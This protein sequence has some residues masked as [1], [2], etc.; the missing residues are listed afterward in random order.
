[1]AAYKYVLAKAEPHKI[2]FV[3]DSA[4]GGLLLATMLAARVENL[5]LPEAAVCYSPLADLAASGAS[6]DKNNRRCAMFYGNSIRRVAPVYL[7]EA[8][9]RNPLA[10]PIYADFRGFP[11]LQIFVSTTE[12]LLDDSIRLAEK[13]RISGVTVDLQVWRNLP[14]VWAIFADRLPEAR[15][16]LRMTAD[17]IERAST[18]SVNKNAEFQSL[19]SSVL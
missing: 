6:L 9:P 17:F 18:V 16:A 3:G 7:G 10:S 14:H 11:P 5:T 13:A 12:V 1:L 15:R 2:A 19:E 4:G 8:N